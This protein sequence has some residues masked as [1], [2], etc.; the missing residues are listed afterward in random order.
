MAATKATGVPC[1]DKAAPDEPLFVIRPTDPAAADAIRD[2][3]YR[4]QAIGHRAE[5]VAGALK[6]A[7]DVEAWQRANPDRV[8]RPD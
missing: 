7:D 6:D 1:Y 3:A 2:W 5:K 8:K 4:A